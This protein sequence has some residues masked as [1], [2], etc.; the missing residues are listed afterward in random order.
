MGCDNLWLR[1]ECPHLVLRRRRRAGKVGSGR[2][3]AFFPFVCEKAFTSAFCDRVSLVA[4]DIH[5]V[6]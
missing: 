6:R 4:G 1:I 5:S 3:R 2:G